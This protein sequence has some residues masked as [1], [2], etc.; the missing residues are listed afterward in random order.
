[1]LRMIGSLEPATLILVPISIIMLALGIW[2]LVTGRTESEKAPF[3]LAVFGFLVLI[4]M[5]VFINLYPPN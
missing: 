5:A 1:M 4:A 2:A 3:S